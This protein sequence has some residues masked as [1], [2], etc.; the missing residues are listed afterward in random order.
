MIT[1]YW[2]GKERHV[3]MDSARVS[4]ILKHLGVLPEVVIVAR[5]GEVVSEE[6]VVRSGDKVKIIKAISGG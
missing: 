6:E 5:N 1:V 4:D 3:E 2:E